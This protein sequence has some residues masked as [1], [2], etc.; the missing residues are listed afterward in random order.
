MPQRNRHHHLPAT[1]DQTKI[2]MVVLL[3]QKS[4]GIIQMMREEFDT[5]HKT[6]GVFSEK[7]PPAK[8]KSIAKENAI[9]IACY[10][11]HS[12]EEEAIE[13][14][15]FEELKQQLVA[16]GYASQKISLEIIRVAT[17]KNTRQLF[18]E[19]KQRISKK[20]PQ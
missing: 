19:A 12:E 16:K 14:S 15:R 7:I 9:I 17:G 18:H 3:P 4:I 6:V 5:E 13:N 10:F 11:V 8:Q 20:I 1:K 2:S